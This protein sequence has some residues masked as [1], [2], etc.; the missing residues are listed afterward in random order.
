MGPHGQD[1][2]TPAEL[3]QPSCSHG[4]EF[5]IDHFLD[6][7]ERSP[8]LERPVPSPCSA[9]CSPGRHTVRLPLPAS[10]PLRVE[11]PVPLPALPFLLRDGPPSP[12]PPASPPPS[13]ASPPPLPPTLLRARSLAELQQQAAAI[14]SSFLGRA[15]G[16]CPGCRAGRALGGPFLCHLCGAMK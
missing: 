13:L 8:P 2:A 3:G 6:S 10:L 9:L 1:R 5:N 7:F 4:E 11:L 12:E 15:G 16:S 14:S